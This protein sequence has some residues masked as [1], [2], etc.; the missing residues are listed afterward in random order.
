MS[1]TEQITPINIIKNSILSSV[2][3]DDKIVEPFTEI[4]GEN[5]KYFNVSKGLFESFRSAKKTIDFYQY[6]KNKNWNDDIDYIFKNRDLLIL[7]WQLDDTDEIKQYETLRIL[8]KA[9]Q[10]DNLHFVS[11][12]TETTN[13]EEILY[14]IKA[15]FD[16]DFND[17]SI[18]ACE[19]LMELLENKLG[20][21]A[22]KL[23]RSYSNDF[24]QVALSA[25][26]VKQKLI[27]DFKYKIKN[28]LA[29]NYRF[30]AKGLNGI[31]ND[32]N[33]ACDILGYYVR[34]EKYTGDIDF[35]TDVKTDYISSMFIFVNHT[36]IQVTNKNSP[37]PND[38]FEFFTDAIQ[39]VAGN[40]LTLISLEVRGLLRESSGFV[41][42]DADI[43]KDE[44]LFHQLEKKEGF[45]DFLMTIIKNHTISYF[46]HKQGRLKSL[47]KDFWDTY[48]SN[49]NL[50]DSISIFNGD[51]NQIFEEIKKLNVYY[52]ALHIKKYPGS[53]L[54]FG[55][56]FYTVNKNQEKDGR[57]YL[58]VTAH[59]DCLNP[60]TNI[61]NNFFFVGGD[62]GDV[63]QLINEGD[64]AFCSYIK[65]EKE[66]SAIKWNPRPVIINIPDSRINDGR[67]IGKDGLDKEYTLLY[68]STI[69]ENYAQRMANN[70]F[71][72]A[73]RVGID[74]ASI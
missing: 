28:E 57:F 71:A 41:G 48:K 11:I 37:K 27:S 5:E 36:I 45:I 30:F 47:N 61:K 21:D 70:S 49:K 8:K 66:I 12:Y 56:I 31:N 51:D 26:E 58:C 29:E 32:I 20:I 53:K 1:E 68:H 18:S 65:D 39:K 2:Y 38:L 40:L 55:D 44:I 69:K 63:K 24:F 4:T 19:N 74:F 60:K 34:G 13:L 9:V 72:H 54:R 17:N 3:I 22:L 62:S 64:S 15:Y 43:I 10:V 25:G 33:K 50:E 46:D 7:D 73:M 59:C 52:N 14:T 35:S 23:F 6:K 16:N 67:L 42:K